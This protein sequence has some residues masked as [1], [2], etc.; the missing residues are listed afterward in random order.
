MGIGSSPRGATVSPTGRRSAWSR[1]SDVLDQ[2]SRFVMRNARTVEFVTLA[3]ATAGIY[4]A[5]TLPTSVFPQTAFPRVVILVDSGVMPADQMMATITRPIEE[6]MNDIPGVESIRSATSRGSAEINVFFDWKV[7]MIQSLMFVQGRLAQLA[8]QIPTTASLQ[9]WRL[10][11]SAFPIIGISLTAPDRDIAD[12]W[13]TARYVIKPR[14]ARVKGVARVD[15]VGG[16][17]P[18][19]HVVADP[20]KL[21]AGGLTLADLVDRLRATNLVAPAGMLEENHQLYLA[22]VSGRLA[23]ADDI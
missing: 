9:V 23:S 22:L 14:L 21:A 15:L 10:T 20:A 6:A 12:V 8:G 13:E 4:T 18:E 11:F 16:R 1:T 3:L 17:E 7:D 5:F 19:F 2:F